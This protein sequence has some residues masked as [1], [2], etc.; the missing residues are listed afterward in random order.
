MILSSI[1]IHSLFK[2]TSSLHLFAF[3]KNRWIMNYFASFIRNKRSLKSNAPMYCEIGFF[4]HLAC[5]HVRHLQKIKTE[6]R[7]ILHVYIHNALSSW[8]V[9]VCVCVFHNISDFIFLN[10]HT[11]LGMEVIS[12]CKSY[13]YKND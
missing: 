7:D 12:C 9:C 2:K 11:W 10:F 4:L 8:N 13:L 6:N 1:F 5:L 3:I